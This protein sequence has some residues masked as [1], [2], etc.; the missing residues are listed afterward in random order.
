MIIPVYE[1][2]MIYIFTLGYKK[3]ITE[4]CLHVGGRFS[5][6]LTTWD[7]STYI[8]LVFIS[9]LHIKAKLFLLK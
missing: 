5:V 8:R 9:Y 3:Y 1:V 4:L 6:T 2:M 7:V